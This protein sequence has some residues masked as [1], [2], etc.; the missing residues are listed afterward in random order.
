M[1]LGEK[2]TSHLAGGWFEEEK[3]SREVICLEAVLLHRMCLEQAAALPVV[4]ETT[5]MCSCILFAHAR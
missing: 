4:I 3:C 2:V 1:G 5:S